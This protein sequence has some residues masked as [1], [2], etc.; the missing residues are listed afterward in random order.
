MPKPR[1]TWGDSPERREKR[2]VDAASALLEHEHER[3]ATRDDRIRIIMRLMVDRRWR[4]ITH[5][6]LARVWGLSPRR[7]K[8]DAD[9]AGARLRGGD[10]ELLKRRELLALSIFDGAAK[11]EALRATEAMFAKVVRVQM[12]VEPELDS[13]DEHELKHFVDV[14]PDDCGL[15]GC[16]VHSAETMKRLMGLDG[17]AE[18]S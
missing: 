13:F 3:P 17:P 5:K 14:A 6:A 18:E 7:I 16:R 10:E 8:E 12:R 2:M 4:R 15:S 1:T 9:V 11:A